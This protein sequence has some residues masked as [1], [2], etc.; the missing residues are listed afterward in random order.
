MNIC[1]TIIQCA[2]KHT[3]LRCMQWEGVHDYV[4]IIIIYIITHVRRL[5]AKILTEG[6]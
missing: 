3:E 4:I 5:I 6:T 1:I 2:S